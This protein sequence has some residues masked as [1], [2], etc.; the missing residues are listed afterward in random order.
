[1]PGAQFHEEY[2]QEILSQALSKARFT[3]TKTELAPSL[4]QR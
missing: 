2:Y 1:M 4:P 3:T